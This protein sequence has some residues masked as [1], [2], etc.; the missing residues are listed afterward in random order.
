MVGVFI[1]AIDGAIMG[2][3]IGGQMGG[4]SI[5]LLHKG[6]ICPLTH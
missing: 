5:E 4:R 6:C 2:Q 3:T 1:G